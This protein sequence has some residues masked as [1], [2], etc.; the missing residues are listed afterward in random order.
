MTTQTENTAQ[1]DDAFS[2]YQREC[3][4]IN[5]DIE[6]KLC[7]SGLDALHACGY[8]TDAKASSIFKRMLKRYGHES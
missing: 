4:L 8:I 1:T 7:L 3:A 2:E 6:G 5:S